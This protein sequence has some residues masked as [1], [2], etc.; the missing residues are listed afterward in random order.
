MFP[1]NRITIQFC[2]FFLSYSAREGNLV[3]VEVR[4][5]VKSAVYF[6]ESVIW[7]SRVKGNKLQTFNECMAKD[8]LLWYWVAL[9]A[10]TFGF[11]PRNKID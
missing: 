1:P 10:K 9:M 4:G 7:E 2:F 3:R 8:V 11:C 6:A 5:S